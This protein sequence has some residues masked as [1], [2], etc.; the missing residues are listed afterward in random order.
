M[1][2]AAELQWLPVTR[3]G[4]SVVPLTAQKVMV[5]T[6]QKQQGWRMER[7]QPACKRCPCVTDTCRFTHSSMPFHRYPTMKECVSDTRSSD[8]VCTCTIS[9]L[10]QVSNSS[11]ATTTHNLLLGHVKHHVQRL[12]QRHLHGEQP[13]TGQLVVRTHQAGQSNDAGRCRLLSMHSRL[14]ADQP[15]AQAGSAHLP[16][17]WLRWLAWLPCSAHNEYNQPGQHKTST[18]QPSAPGQTL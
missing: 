17:T 9:D 15:T 6:R 4:T 11:I 12:S 2:R 5:C 7:F 10:S 3:C 16:H 8:Q 18:K 13:N 1:N 14:R